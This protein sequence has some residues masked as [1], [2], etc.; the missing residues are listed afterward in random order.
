MSRVIEHCWHPRDSHAVLGFARPDR[1]RNALQSPGCRRLGCAFAP[2]LYEEG[3]GVKST[4]S[5]LTSSPLECRVSA[6]AARPPPAPAP[7]PR[8]RTSPS[9]KPRPEAEADGLRPQRRRRGSLLSGS[10][11]CSSLIKA[12]ARCP[13]SYAESAVSRVASSSC[14]I[15]RMTAG[16]RSLK[17]TL[18]PAR[19]WTVT[20]P[21][22]VPSRRS[23]HQAGGFGS[24]SAFLIRS[25]E[26]E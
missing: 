18:S 1:R 9:G 7:W 11:E 16:A 17:G 24:A 13:L 19:P 8:G 6:G 26:N 3:P 5:L 2:R 21:N 14:A 12:G 15:W 4:V 22:Q 10:R 23:R 20:A 25:T